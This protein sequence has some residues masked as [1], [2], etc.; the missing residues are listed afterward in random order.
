MNLEIK[1]KIVL[2]FCL[3]NRV[4]NITKKFKNN[5]NIIKMNN[6]IIIKRSF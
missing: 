6:N 1:N 4:K 5:N 3:L 2:I